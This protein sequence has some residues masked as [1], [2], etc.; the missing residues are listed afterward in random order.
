MGEWPDY[1][2]D[3]SITFKE[4]FPVVL[5]L[6]IWGCDLSNK[7][8]TLHIDN[9]AAVYILNKQSSKDKDIMCLVRRFVLACMKFNILTKC[10]H[11]SGHSNTLPDLISRFQADA[12]LQASPE[13]DRVPTQVPP[14]LLRVDL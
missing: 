10:V 14:D 6:E 11:V 7:C 3:F 8:I 1:L 2:A 12:F 4:I 9:A 13:M 5:A